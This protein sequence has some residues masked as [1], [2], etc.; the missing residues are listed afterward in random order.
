GPEVHG[1]ALDEEAVTVR[2][3]PVASVTLFAGR[4][5]GSR[6][7]VGRLGYPHGAEILERDSAGAITAV[8][9]E[10]L[11]NAPYGRLELADAAGRKAWT[12]P[13][14]PLTAAG[15]PWR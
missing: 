9:L 8:R 11:R 13:L 15:W 1:L 6:A 7:N 4:R 12:K 3:S 2:C 5:R 10:R 14:R